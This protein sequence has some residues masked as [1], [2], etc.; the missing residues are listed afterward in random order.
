MKRQ[1]LS[2]ITLTGFIL[3]PI[4]LWGH[5]Q[6]PCGIYDD[7]LR[8][9]SIRED[10]ETIEKAMEEIETL[11]EKVDE[12][13]SNYNQLVRWVDTKEDHAQHIQDVV[14]AYFLTQRIKPTDPKDPVYIA[15]T[16]LLQQLLV[17]VMK[18]KQTLDPAHVEHSRELLDVFIDSYFDEHGKEHLQA[19]DQHK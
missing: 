19:L 9:V 13:A 17:S 14:S 7:A 8:I 11:S 10:L 15:Q 18:C 3:L 6:V 12:T 2:S 5:C 1:L 16:T 4:I